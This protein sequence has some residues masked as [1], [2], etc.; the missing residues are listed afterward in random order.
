M[1]EGRRVK[2][3]WKLKYK[4][5]YYDVFIRAIVKINHCVSV[6]IVVFSCSIFNNKFNFSFSIVII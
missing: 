1:R 2:R 5:V 6:N 4:N 3:N